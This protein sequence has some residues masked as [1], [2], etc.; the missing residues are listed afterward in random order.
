MS[1]LKLKELREARHLS[2]RALAKRTKLGFAH[3]Q[4]VETHQVSPSLRTLD[5][6]AKALNVPV[7][8]L[9]EP[10]PAKPRTVTYNVTH[11][12]D[13]L[14]TVTYTKGPTRVFGGGTVKYTPIVDKEKN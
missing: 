9:I 6:L 11:T 2:L 3:L 5:R 1:R 13:P 8:D 10:T 4:K 7:T 14:R 12:Q